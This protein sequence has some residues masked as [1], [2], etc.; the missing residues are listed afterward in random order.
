M[1]KT[2][3]LIGENDKKQCITSLFRLDI[4]KGVARALSYTQM[5][6]APTNCLTKILIEDSS[7]LA[8][9]RRKKIVTD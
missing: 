2:L 7:L 8:F 5:K 4:V 1:R 9:F 3:T 6:I